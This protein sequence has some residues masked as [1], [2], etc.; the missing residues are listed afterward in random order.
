[1]LII[2]VD[3]LRLYGYHGYYAEERILGSWYEY[4]VIYEGSINT[5]EISDSL[6]N[7][8]N[9]ETIVQTCKEVN[10]SPVSLIETLTY[11][12]AKR[13]TAKA[14]KGKITVKLIKRNPPFGN[15][16][17]NVSCT[18]SITNN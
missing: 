1:M 2:E 17:A 13:L 7:T 9:Y 6:N 5:A 8:F 10:T 18:Y 11:E 15:I 14:P 3:S 4:S 16:N 12:I